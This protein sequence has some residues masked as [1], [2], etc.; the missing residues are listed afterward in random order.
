MKKSVLA[1]ALFAAAGILSA[2][3]SEVGAVAVTGSV[4]TDNI[5]VGNFSK[6]VTEARVGLSTNVGAVGLSAQV[7]AGDGTGVQEHDVSLVASYP[8]AVDAVRGLTVSPLLGF[9]Y[10]AIN[11]PGSRFTTD[12]YALGASASMPIPHTAFVANAELAAGHTFNP[13]VGSD[14]LY[15][16]AV[17]GVSTPAA[18]GLVSANWIGSKANV[19]GLNTSLYQNRVEVGY[20]YAF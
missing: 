14:G 15:E 1:L 10:Q 13:N 17:V 11:T 7:A 16:L 4:G 20:S 9:G 6:S 12:R 2:Q 3:A 19:E 18:G 8:I 5:N